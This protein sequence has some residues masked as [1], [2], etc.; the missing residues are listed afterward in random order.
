MKKINWLKIALDV[1]KY[2]ITAILGALGYS[3]L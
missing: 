3:I 2:A 1:L